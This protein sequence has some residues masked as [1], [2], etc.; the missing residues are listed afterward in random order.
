MRAKS[1][2]S[3]RSVLV[4][5]LI[6]PALALGA[7]PATVAAA[8][9]LPAEATV[10]TMAAPRL[11][12]A[13]R[14]TLTLDWPDVAQAASYR[15]RYSRYSS[16]K[17]SRTVTV[18]A[19]RAVL[20]GL[21]AVTRYYVVVQPVPAAGSAVSSMAA[22]ARMTFKTMAYA[23]PSGLR[24]QAS[25]RSADSVAVNWL[26]TT[27]GRH[28]QVQY[29]TTSDFAA[30]G[31]VT[32]SVA[33]TSISGLSTGQLYY[34]RVR[35]LSAK[36]SVTS[37]WSGAVAAIPQVPADPGAVPLGVGSFN[38]RNWNRTSGGKWSDRGPLIAAEI[39]SRNLD[40]VGLQE[41]DFH[42]HGG[43]TQYGSL[44]NLLGARGAGAFAAVEVGT[45]AGT[46]IIYNTNTVTVVRGGMRQLSTIGGD[47][48]RYVVWAEF[49]QN[50]TGRHFF[51][52][53]THLVPETHP[54]ATKKCSSKQSKRYKM[55]KTQA[56]QVIAEIQ[57]NAGGLPVVL[58]GDMNSHK[59]QCP[60][61]APYRAYVASGLVDPL[62][63]PDRSKLPKNPTT[64]VRIH[65]EWDTSNHY[66][67]KPIRH[68]I[69][70]GHHVDYVFVSPTI[71]T[72]TYEVVV[73]I[74]DATL[75]YVGR[76]PSDHNLV[77]AEILIP[78]S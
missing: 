20:T 53:T 30:A 11:A 66:S 13:T 58:T 77:R 61:N 51:F 43:V 5:L 19:S 12:A 60:T 23:A 21:K 6:A 59:V 45:T 39:D 57:A 18:T 70:N 41:A 73:K 17:S 49:V 25:A 24:A 7:L 68:N 8:P 72:L 69:V 14:T 28:Y 55:R 3:V 76:H 34:F 9:A 44:I 1:S 74:N 65:S 2:I 26:F 50:A 64:E 33:S 48:K 29:A 37:G 56:G 38:I 78:A 16:L 67:R 35:S 54:V 31:M 63:N 47:V 10:T 62:G 42:L 46:R 36:G 22:S 71:K 52:A 75:K 4:A 27:P 32:T 15:V 40:V